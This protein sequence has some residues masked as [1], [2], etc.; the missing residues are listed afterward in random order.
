MTARGLQQAS[1]PFFLELTRNA[2]GGC[3]R[4]A[5]E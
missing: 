3:V 4:H 1:A 2:R 5:L